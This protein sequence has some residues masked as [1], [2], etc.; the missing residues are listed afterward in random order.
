MC[1]YQT[2]R[3]PELY[4]TPLD[5]TSLKFSAGS[6][7]A[8]NSLDLRCFNSVVYYHFG[9]FDLQ[10]VCWTFLKIELGFL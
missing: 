2:L 4:M 1:K 10:F 3:A 8:G 7:Q 6:T 9:I 5:W